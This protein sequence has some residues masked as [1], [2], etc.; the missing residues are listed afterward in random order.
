MTSNIVQLDGLI[1]QGLQPSTAQGLDHQ[2]S[3]QKADQILH[4]IGELRKHSFLE[5]TVTCCY[6]ISTSET[7]PD[8]WP[9]VL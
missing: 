3:D 8:S 2:I 9:V 5:T 7:D 1:D 6:L 4:G